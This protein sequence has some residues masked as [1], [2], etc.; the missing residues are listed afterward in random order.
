MIDIADFAV[1]LSRQLYGLTMHSERPR[2]RMYEQWHP[3]GSSACITRVQLPGRRVE[4]ERADRGG[5]RRLRGLEAVAKDAA[6][7]DRGAAHLQPVLERHG[8]QGVLNL[9]IG[10]R[11]RVGERMLD[12]PRVP[13]ISATGSTRMGNTSRRV[14]GAAA[15][16]HAARTGRQQRRDR[17]GRC[18]T[19]TWR[20]GPCCSARSA[21]RA[22]AAPR[23]R[24]L[25][26]QQGIAPRITERLMAAYKQVRIGDP[27]DPSTLM[28]PLIDRRGGREHAAGLGSHSRA[29]RRGALRRA[30]SLEDCFRRADA[31]ARAR[32]SCRS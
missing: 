30:A 31:R 20:C 25:F 21:R 6:D 7:R 3:L 18:R 11:R 8:W 10:A 24:R 26:L 17:D 4:L 2:H 28:G 5:L 15:G 23:I 14:V 16:A 13:L 27:L 12:D 19:S 1:G 22:S 29:G 9:V 32:R